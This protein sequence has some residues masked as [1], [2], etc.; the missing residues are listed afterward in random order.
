MS[1]EIQFWVR[2]MKLFGMNSDR[3]YSIIPLI[4]IMFSKENGI[5]RNLF[6]RRNLFQHVPWIGLCYAFRN[7][8]YLNYFHIVYANNK[9]KENHDDKVSK[10]GFRL[11]FSRR[12]YEV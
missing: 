11:A 6:R 8:I 7:Y 5:I 1:N 2:I 9:I 12:T 3:N 10:F 4:S